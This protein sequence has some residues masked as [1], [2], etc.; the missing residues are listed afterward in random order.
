MRIFACLSLL[1][2]LTGPAYASHA[3]GDGL[4]PDACSNTPSKIE[5]KSSPVG[6]QNVFAEK[7]GSWA[8][9]NDIGGVRSP[10]FSQRDS[11]PMGAA[12][13]AAG[14]PDSVAY[15]DHSHPCAPT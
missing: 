10:V 13:R 15:G 12:L 6:V 5:A 14:P 7:Y 1:A 9:K 2:I 3:A 4:R 11:F 8:G